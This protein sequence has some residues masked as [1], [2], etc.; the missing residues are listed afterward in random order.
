MKNKCFYFKYYRSLFAFECVKF[1][2]TGRWKIFFSP[3]NY[4]IEDRSPILF[5]EHT[6]DKENIW[7]DESEF[8]YDYEPF[9]YINECNTK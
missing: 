3:N 8:L 2:P 4:V 1:V 6:G 5:L 7:V 9:E